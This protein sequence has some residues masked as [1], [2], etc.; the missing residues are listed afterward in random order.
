MFTA[1]MILSCALSITGEFFP[2][3]WGFTIYATMVL[4]VA[5]QCHYMSW[6]YT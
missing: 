6:R 4:I 1:M 2:G 5:W 3:E